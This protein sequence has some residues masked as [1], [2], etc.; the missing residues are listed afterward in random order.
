MAYKILI[1]EDDESLRNALC[2]KFIKEGFTVL[3]AQ[4]GEEGLKMALQQ[5]PDLILLDILMPKMDGLTMLRK[6]RETDKDKKVPVILLSN[7][8]DVKDISEAL[9]LGAK[10]YLVKTAWKLEDLVAKV[11]ERIKI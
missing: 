7:L 2:D 10:E 6:F 8:S 4:D 3:K 9:S 11:N 5:H 1:V